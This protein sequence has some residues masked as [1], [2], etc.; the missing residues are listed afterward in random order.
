MHKS[1]RNGPSPR[2]SCLLIPEVRA[3]NKNAAT[4]ILERLGFSGQIG[5]GAVDKLGASSIQ[6]LDAVQLSEAKP[7]IVYRAG[8]QSI[9]TILI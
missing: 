5:A 3:Q 1:I 9:I 6:I 4:G 7:L 2:F 8:R